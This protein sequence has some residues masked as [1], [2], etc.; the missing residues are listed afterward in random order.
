MR[1]VLLL[2]RLFAILLFYTTSR[3]SYSNGFVN[4]YY[5]PGSITER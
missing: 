5:L 2:A 4:G 3:S 1:K